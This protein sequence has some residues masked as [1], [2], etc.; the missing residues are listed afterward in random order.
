MLILPLVSSLMLTPPALAVQLHCSYI[1]IKVGSWYSQLV[2][3]CFR[4]SN[5]DLYP[6][7][8]LSTALSSSPWFFGSAPHQRLRLI[9]LFRF[10]IM[11]PVPR[12]RDS[13]I[14]MELLIFHPRRF[15]NCLQN[16]VGVPIVRK[17]P[18]A[19]TESSLP[20]LGYRVF[21]NFINLPLKLSV[22]RPEK[23][24]RLYD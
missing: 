19:K 1:S 23:G 17:H 21:P 20:R 10:W 18:Y 13:V 8:S 15:G 14:R 24:Q 5:C 11:V 22:A 3:R 2:Y 9:E 4:T 12:R 16:E 7:C 6:P